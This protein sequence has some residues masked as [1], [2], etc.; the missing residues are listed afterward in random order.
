MQAKAD[1]RVTIDAGGKV[2]I[3]DAAPP[4]PAYPASAALDTS[5]SGLIQEPPKTGADDKGK[6]YSDKNYALLCGPGTAAVVLY[7]W[8]ATHT[9]V[10][11]KSGT[12][13]EPVNLGSGKYASTYWKPVD[14]GGNARGMI[15]YIADVEWPAPDKGI[16]W[17]PRPGLMNWSAARPSTNR[18]NL[19]D[20][21][22][23]E[24]SG[25]TRLNYFYVIVPSSQLTAPALRDHV[26]ADI[27]MGVPVVIAARTSDGTNSL[28]YWRVKSKKSSGNHF[29]TVVG[30]NDTTG[31]YAVMDTCGVAC[32]D[33]NMRAGVR[34]MSQAALFSLIRAESDDDGIIW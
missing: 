8:A 11:T 22:N 2:V 7:Y 29:V 33:R 13:V 6:S 30:Y 15:M 28:P 27:K 16:W 1:G 26:H 14:A 21:I 3:L 4:T 23:W 12:F 19:V 18:E 34:N 9:T 20:A 17:W 25:R 10:T 5:W 24:T 32:N 31:T